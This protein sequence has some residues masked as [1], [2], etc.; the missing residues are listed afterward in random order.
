MSSLAI[1]LTG[2]CVLLDVTGQLAFKLGLQRLPELSGGFKLLA[3]WRQLAGAPL[4]WT[5]VSAYALQFVLWLAA[6]SMAPLS[7]VFPIMS[8]SYCGVVLAGGLI[9]GEPI[10]RRRWAGTVLIT[11]GVI[12]VC[13]TGN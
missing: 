5:G 9:L 11:A 10:S 2:C 8:L 3:F 1:P 7:T 6:L 4:L 12:L 13:G